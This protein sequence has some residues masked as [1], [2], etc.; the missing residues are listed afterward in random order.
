MTCWA[1]S[2]W[3]PGIRGSSTAQAG[4]TTEEQGCRLLTPAR[5]P[6]KLQAIEAESP[7]T[8]AGLRTTRDTQDWL[9]LVRLTPAEGAQDPEDI[10]T[11][12]EETG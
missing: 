4:L 1:C 8:L 6:P 11:A 9:D 12:V 2:G 10:W 5:E 7:K 3:R